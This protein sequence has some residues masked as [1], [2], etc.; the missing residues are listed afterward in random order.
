MNEGSAVLEK[1]CIVLKNDGVFEK[2][3]ECACTITSRY[4]KSVGG[5]AD[6]GVLCV[7]KEC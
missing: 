2:Y 4:Y 6:N 3:S 7:K 1:F 5:F